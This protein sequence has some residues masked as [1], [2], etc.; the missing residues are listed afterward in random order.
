MGAPVGNL[1]I[2]R[3]NHD[4]PFANSLT[5]ANIHFGG[6]GLEQSDKNTIEINQNRM[7]KLQ[8]VVKVHG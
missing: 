8:S 3:A 5:A 2:S 7:E 4:I 6:Q 1:A